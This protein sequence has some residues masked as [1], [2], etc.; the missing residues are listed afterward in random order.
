MQLTFYPI[1]VLVFYSFC[2]LD[3][4]AAIA[5]S[6]VIVVF[7]SPSF[8]CYLIRGEAFCRS[9]AAPL[10]AVGPDKT[11]PSGLPNRSILFSQL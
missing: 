1:F 9:P 8:R 6:N 5:T 11:K 4:L 2:G 10:T 7:V 3:L